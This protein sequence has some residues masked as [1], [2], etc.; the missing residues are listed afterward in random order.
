MGEHESAVA[1]LRRIE[2]RALSHSCACTDQMVRGRN[3]S[4]GVSLLESVIGSV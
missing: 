4:G 2:R 1:R 3:Y